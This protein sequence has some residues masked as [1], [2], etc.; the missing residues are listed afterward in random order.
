V[1]ALKQNDANPSKIAVDD[2]G[3]QKTSF[4]EEENSISPAPLHFYSPFY[5]LPP[6]LLTSTPT[7]SM[8][9]ISF[10]KKQSPYASSTSL[11]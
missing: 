6:F 2:D 4:E 10:S 5:R 9:N 8:S 1:D 3:K 7:I 11:R